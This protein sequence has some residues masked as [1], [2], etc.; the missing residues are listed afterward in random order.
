MSLATHAPHEHLP[1]GGRPLGPDSLTWQ[2]FADTRMALLGPRAAVLQNM[3]PSLGQG[4]QDHSVWFAE[5]LARLQRSIPPIFTTVY[6]ADPIGSGHQVRDFHT[7]IKGRLPDGKPYSA[8]NPDTYYWAHATF[9]EHMVVATETFIRPLTLDELDQIIAESV[10]WFARYGVS[11]RSVPRTWA[12]FDAYFDETLATRLVKH[13]T[14]SY[15]VGYAVKGWPRPARVHPLLWWFVRRPLDAVSASV[16]IGGM[17]QKGREILDLPWDAARE[18]RYRRFATVVRAADPLIRRL[19]R[20]LTMHPIA[21][22]GFSR[23]AGDANAPRLPRRHGRGPQ[24]PDRSRTTAEQ[25]E[26]AMKQLDGM[27]VAVTGGARGIGAATARAL[28]DAGARVVIG[29]LDLDLAKQEAQSYGGVALPLDVADRASFQE[30]LDGVVSQHGRLDALV[31]NAGFM[32]IGRM[33]DVSLDRQL[34]QLDVNLTGVITGSYE[35]AARMTRGGVIVNIASLAGRIPMPGAAVYCATKAGVLAFSEALEAELDEQGIRVAAV[36]PSFTNTQLIEGTEA[37]GLMKPIQPADV[38]DAVVRL[39]ASPKPVTVV[40]RRFAASGAS[41]SMTSARVKPWLRAR[42][43]M[44]QVFTEP[45]LDRR[46][47][48]DQ[49]TGG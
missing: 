36:L 34:A 6:G 12:E 28:A 10:T 48:Y 31:N 15:G 35:G 29:D 14:A 42:L 47:A 38:A 44:D 1:E 7:T 4:V 17:P 45:D 16:T 32:V 26:Q 9:V 21:V 8:L 22:A 2:L 37:S 30:F 41:W 33:Q 43:G 46:A 27:V 23:V 13:R 19:P 49:R 39:V 40:P 20:R 3:L 11:A 5:I 24:R 25:K 18:R